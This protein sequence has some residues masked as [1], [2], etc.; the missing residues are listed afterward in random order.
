MR[1]CCR[2][3]LSEENQLL[4]LIPSA[5]SREGQEVTQALLSLVREAQVVAG[6][7]VVRTA[8][9]T[10]RAEDAD[11]IFGAETAALLA[12]YSTL[13]FHLQGPTVAD[14]NIDQR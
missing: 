14:L 6:V 4:L 9:I 7:D 10:V 11:G 3:V 13:A 8:K 12:G 1:C 5:D 2:K